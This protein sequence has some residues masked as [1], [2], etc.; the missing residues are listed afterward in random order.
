MEGLRN[1]EIAEKLFV[2]IYTVK[3][4]LKTIFV[5]LD[6]NSRFH[7]IKKAKDLDFFVTA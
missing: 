3:K 1:K 6:V 4:H 2:S 7:A 5:K